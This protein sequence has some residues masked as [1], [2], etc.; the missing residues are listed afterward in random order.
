MIDRAALHALTPARRAALIYSEA[1]SA[2]SRDLWQAALGSSEDRETRADRIER[3]NPLDALLEQL[4][5]QPDTQSQ[6]PVAR[7]AVL[8]LMPPSDPLRSDVDPDG[9]GRTGHG[10]LGGLGVNERHQRTLEDAAARTGI[11]APALAAIVDAEAGKARDGSWQVYSRN[12]RS[13]AAGLGQFLS[14]TWEGLAETGGTW[15]NAHARGQGWIGGDGQLLAS[16]RPALL[17]LRY[18]AVASING[19]ADYARRNLDGLRRAGVDGAGEIG[20]TARLAYLGHH[21]GLGDAIRFL[22]Q[23][24]LSQ[25][26][27]RV[28]LDAQVGQ[29][30]SQRRIAAVGDATA[31]HRSWLLGYL[32][33]KVRADRYAAPMNVA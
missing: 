19:I 8:R 15:L 27:A 25:A 20:A 5:R 17:A 23:G 7:P 1:Q 16:A 21:L 31:A 28:L 11:P 6:A 24:G 12:P 3:R 22:R 18:D 10:G 33:R 2:V 26:R 4:Q 14:R 29:P 32:D 13:S 30:V 9:A